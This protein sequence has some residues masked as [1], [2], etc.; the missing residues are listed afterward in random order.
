LSI[1]WSL[2]ERERRRRLRAKLRIGIDQLDRGE[3]IPFTPALLDEIDREV[4]ER[5]RRGDKPNPDDC[6]ETDFRACSR[7]ET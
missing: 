5:I 1:P 2:G 6:P 7:V 3:A 4:D